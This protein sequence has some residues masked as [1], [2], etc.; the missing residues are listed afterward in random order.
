MHEHK[1][2]HEKWPKQMDAPK[3]TVAA[4]DMSVSQPAQAVGRFTSALPDAAFGL[5][6]AWEPG[7]VARSD[8]Y[9]AYSNSPRLAT[10]LNLANFAPLR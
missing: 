4:L 10:Y 3:W 7:G 2:E 1:H 9:G 5:E 6:Q 8:R